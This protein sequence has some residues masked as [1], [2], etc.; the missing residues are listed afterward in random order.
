MN[1]IG[2]IYTNFLALKN[3]GSNIQLNI[4]GYIFSQERIE[5]AMIENFF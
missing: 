1:T 2:N 4:S 3:E 5:D